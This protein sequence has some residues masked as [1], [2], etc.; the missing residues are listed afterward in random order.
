MSPTLSICVLTHDS[1]PRLAPLLQ[2]ASA[3][4]DEVV[5]V[6]SASTD[7]TLALAAQHPKVR[8]V[9]RPFDGNFAKQ[10][11]FGI[12]QARSDWILFLDTDELLSPNAM[13]LMP[14]LLR[15]PYRSVKLPIYWLAQE[16][17]PLFVKTPKHYPC[18]RARLFRRLPELR[19]IE[20]RPLHERLP[21]DPRH[22][23][24]FLRYTHILHYSFLWLD[25]EERRRK[26]E[27][28]ERL[29]KDMSHI[30]K[31]YAYEEWSHHLM[32]CAESWVDG[33]PYMTWRGRLGFVKDCCRV[34]FGLSVR[35]KK[36]PKK[37]KKHSVAAGASASDSDRLL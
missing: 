1:G 13:R 16:N 27:E 31:M 22:P 17:P 7:G 24:L 6:D 28:Y 35:W 29:S 11:N 15:C 26:I 30:N 32:P 19:Y 18:R 37:R 5:L 21:D 36:L 25:A 3:V 8:V 2:Q 14:Y 9:Q 33:R 4:A 34:L 10:R 23:C 20:D 12:D